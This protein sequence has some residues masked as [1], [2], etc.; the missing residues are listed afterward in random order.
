MR[1]KCQL[2]PRSTNNPRR[3]PGSVHS[4]S[5]RV[6]R[7]AWRDWRRA[8]RAR[9]ERRS[10]LGAGVSSPQRRAQ[11]SSGQRRLYDWHVLHQLQQRAGAGVELSRGVLL[12]DVARLVVCPPPGHDAD[13]DYVAG[14][15]VRGGP[16]ADGVG[17]HGVFVPHGRVFLNFHFPFSLN[18]RRSSPSAPRD[19]LCG[20]SRPPCG[21]VPAPGAS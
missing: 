9:A 4:T 13:G 3:L 6:D 14:I 1:P 12:A 17:G 18:V 10:R 5:P 11:T 2:R 16:G 20:N 15:R 19:C 7:Q 21:P 8:A